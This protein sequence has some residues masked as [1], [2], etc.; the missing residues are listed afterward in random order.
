MDAGLNQ[1]QSPLFYRWGGGPPG[2]APACLSPFVIQLFPSADGTSHPPAGQSPTP[3]KG[4]EAEKDGHIV[5]F[6]PEMRACISSL[7]AVTFV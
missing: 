6:S 7:S 5:K 2:P 3:G 1:N 4:W